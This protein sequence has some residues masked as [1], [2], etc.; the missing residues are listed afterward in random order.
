[1]TAF[2]GSTQNIETKS[3]TAKQRSSIVI[4][5][6]R[7]VAC[8]A[9]VA[10]AAGTWEYLGLLVRTRM[11][12]QRI[13][14]C[15]SIGRSVCCLAAN[16]DA[17]C[18]AWCTVKL[19]QTSKPRL[20]SVFRVS[21]RSSVLTIGQEF[22]SDR[23][24]H[25]SFFLNFCSCTAPILRPIAVCALQVSPR[26][27]CPPSAATPRC[28]PTNSASPRPR[29]HPRRTFSTSG[30]MTTCSPRPRLLPR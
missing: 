29:V 27:P 13:M 18:R 22:S 14:W 11:H 28:A 3:R 25:L 5:M 21:F 17:A 4:E 24:L 6:L 8:T 10:T 19:Q 30:A 26:P 9:I 12:L 20:F 7:A 1:M 23:M 2:A 15:R 16:N